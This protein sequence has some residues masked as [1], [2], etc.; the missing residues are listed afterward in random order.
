MRISQTIIWKVITL[1]GELELRACFFEKVYDE[2]LSNFCI[3]FFRTY[4]DYQYI[5]S[6]REN[7]QR[8]CYN[9]AKRFRVKYEYV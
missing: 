9:I 2:R 8:V 3:I 4:L 1:S 6:P 7:F 5:L